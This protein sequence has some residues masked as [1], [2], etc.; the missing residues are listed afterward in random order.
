LV[1]C[2][3][4]HLTYLDANS[5]YAIAQSE[6]LPVDL[7]KV[8]ICTGRGHSVAAPLQAVQLVVVI[9]IIIILPLVV[10]IPRV[11]NSVPWG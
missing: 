9:I 8:T 4:H 1:G 3:S 2:S 6:P 7:H 5:L 10:K 11:K